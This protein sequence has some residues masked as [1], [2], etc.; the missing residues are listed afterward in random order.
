MKGTLIPEEIVMNKIF[1]IRGMKVMIDKDLAELYQVQTR[2]LNQAVNRNLKRFPGED[3]MFQLTENESKNLKFQ[4]GTSS[5]G[6]TRKLPYVFTE[7]GVAMLSGILNSDI[8]I[9]VNVQIMRVF[10]RIRQMLVETT[11]LRLEI[12]K[13]KD[14]LNNQ[15]KNMEI[16]FK[17]LD[18]LVEKQNAPNP[19]RTRIGFKPDAY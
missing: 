15:D 13:I 5:W 4:I 17:Y 19:P 1:L 2:N 9:A 14:K 18:E 6:G 8:A 3:F 11:D 10:T 12:E 7:Q 16:V